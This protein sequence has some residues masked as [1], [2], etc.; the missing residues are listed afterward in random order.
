M[1]RARSDTALRLAFC[2]ALL[3]GLCLSAPSA[4]SAEVRVSNFSNLS[5]GIYSGSGPLSSDI[6]LCVYSDTGSY[7]VTVT[8]SGSGSSFT[9]NSGSNAISYSVY[10]NDTSGTSGSVQITTPGSPLGNQGGAHETE[11][12]CNGGT[13]ANLEVRFSESN[14]QAAKAGSY[15]GTVYVTVEPN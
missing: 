13:N 15:S 2:G 6:D 5:F 9:I 3:L 14:L 11:P 8:G 4:W 1:N 10:W 7:D 12:D